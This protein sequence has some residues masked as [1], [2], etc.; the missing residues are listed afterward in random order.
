M[1][2]DKRGP[3]LELK[4]AFTEL[5]TKMIDSKQ[6]MRL[7]DLQVYPVDPK[8]GQDGQKTPDT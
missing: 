2:G 6:K 5:Q 8:L 1:S 4:K 7:A 3:D